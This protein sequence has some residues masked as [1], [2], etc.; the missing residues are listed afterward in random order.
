VKVN[1]KE[2]LFLIDKDYEIWG[3]EEE[4]LLGAGVVSF[5]PLL[6]LSFFLTPVVVSVA[7]FVWGALLVVIRNY[8]S[9]ENKR[10]GIKRKVLVFLER[11]ILKRDVYYA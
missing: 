2:N 6:F 3:L 4:E 5:V 11:K 8:K 10:G 9:R 7:P 1:E